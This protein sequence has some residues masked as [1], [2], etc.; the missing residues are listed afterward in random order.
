MGIGKTIVQKIHLSRQLI[1]MILVLLGT[2]KIDFSRPL[3]QIEKAIL[4][5]QIADTVVVQSGHTNFSSQ[6]LSIQKFMT[7]AELN[8]LYQEAEVVITHAGVGSILRGLQMGKKVIAVPRLYKYK[9]HVD[10]HQLDILNE[11]AAQ[12][13]L[14]PWH[15][16]DSFQSLLEMA[17]TFVPNPYRSNKQDLEQ[18]LISYIERN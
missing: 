14:I 16:T 18:F 12:G 5:G 1:L 9:E 3:I 15:E 13:Y 7:S 2:F 11:F 10:D 4:D 6:V 8:V 17:K